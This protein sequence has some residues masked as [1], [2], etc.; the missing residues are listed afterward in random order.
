MALDKAALTGHVP[1]AR[2]AL[3]AYGE[4]EAWSSRDHFP[5]ALARWQWA[6]GSLKNALLA[7]DEPRQGFGGACVQAERCRLLLLNGNI[8]ACIAT[9]NALLR[10]AS[11]H[12]WGDLQ[13][14]SELVLGA[15]ERV[16][17]ST[18]QPLIAAS[19]QSRWVHLYLGALHLDAIRRRGRGENVMPQLRTLRS[20]ASDL[21]HLMYEALANPKGW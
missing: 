3:M 7:T 2:R 12:G 21:G 11:T 16:D 10:S 17:D 6:R 13:K 20:R 9:S 4:K 8:D 1:E 15:A 19:R 18:Y 14:F 5:A